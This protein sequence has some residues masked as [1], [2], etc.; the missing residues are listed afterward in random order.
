[1]KTIVPAAVYKIDSDQSAIALSIEETASSLRRMATSGGRQEIRGK[2][3]ELLSAIPRRIRSAPSGR[4]DLWNA[5]RSAVLSIDPRKLPFPCGARF[6][7]WRWRLLKLP[8][9]LAYYSGTM[10]VFRRL[11]RGAKEVL[12]FHNVMPDALC[13]FDLASGVTMSASR[14]EAMMRRLCRRYRFSADFDD[15]STLTVTFDAGY[16]CQF[17][18]AGERLRRLG[19]PAVVFVSGALRNA[20]RPERALAVDR[21]LYWASY[22]PMEALAGFAGAAVSS[23]AE[24]WHEFMNPAYR[25][26]AAARGENVFAK[27]DSIWPFA[28]AVAPLGAETLRLRLAG[29]DAGRVEQLKAE[30][31]KIGWHTRTHFPLAFLSDADAESELTPDD[32]SCLDLPM[33]YPYGEPVAVSR[34]DEEIAERACFRGGLSNLAVPGERES[35][36]FLPRITLTGDT[37][38]DESMLSGFRYFLETGRLLRRFGLE[39]KDNGG[40]ADGD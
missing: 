28:K 9:A 32:P 40:A 3:R 26:D 34:R 1:M 15:P 21:L 27:A 5:W 11:N 38:G 35:R 20:D 13:A 22:A 36:F 18:T 4:R 30:G 29:P 33:S 8:R 17:E 24:F 2:V 25:R 6:R 10:A 12:T 16:R 31:W 7:L 37:I 23:R 14:F 39:T 19:V